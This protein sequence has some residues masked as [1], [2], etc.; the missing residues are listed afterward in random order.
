MKKEEQ[1][2]RCWQ[3]G[4]FSILLSTAGLRLT[5][6]LG[7]KT[8]VLSTN[9][10]HLL[11]RQPFLGYPD[12]NLS[13]EK[14]SFLSLLEIL[15]SACSPAPTADGN[16][17]TT[18]VSSARSDHQCKPVLNRPELVKQCCQI[19][20]R[21][22]STVI[23]YSCPGCS[24]QCIPKFSHLEEIASDVAQKNMLRYCEAGNA[25]N[26]TTCFRSPVW[27][28]NS[29]LN[30]GLRTW[31]LQRWRGSLQ[32]FPIQSP[33]HCVD[34]Q[35]IQPGLCCLHGNRRSASNLQG[36]CGIS[37]RVV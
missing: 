23:G 36:N 14:S 34:E 16:G 37:T 29:P 12:V 13:R 5:W 35:L 9:S 26:H 30:A 27:H 20:V 24:F 22:P 32:Q 6:H 25:G 21:P 7:I 15:A 8:A 17:S 33:W 10:C 2:Y 1:E 3:R 28:A 31:T 19:A 11:P 4:I 18:L